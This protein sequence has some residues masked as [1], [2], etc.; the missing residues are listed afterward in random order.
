MAGGKVSARQKMINMMYLV[1]LA[2]L[3]MNVSKE[4]LDSF[5]ILKLKLYN[6][7]A[8]AEENAG[9]LI[10]AMKAEIDE[11]VDNQGK[12][13]NVGLKDSLDLVRGRT[14]A[15]INELN[16]HVVEMETIA[17]KDET[18]GEIEKKD[19]LEKNYQYWMGD[20]DV[21]NGGRG[22]GKAFELRNNMDQ[23]N[24]FLR[25]VYNDNVKDKERQLPE[26]KLED[27]VGKEGKTKSWEQYTFDGPVVANMAML[28][29]LKVDV[30]EKQKE[31]LT[32]LNERLGVA[33][34]KADKVIALVAPEA[35]IVPAGL[36]YRAKLFAVLSSDNIKPTFSS[37][38]GAVKPDSSGSF[39]NL[40]IPASGG[41]IPKGKAEG[42]Q[43]WTATVKVPKATGGTEDLQVSGK[44]TV[45]R[46]EIV[47][48]S[49]SIQILY[50]NCGNDVNIDVP[51]LGDLYNPQVTA[52]GGSVTQSPQN[53]KLFRVVP[54]A[55]KCR[56]HVASNT[57][58]RKIDIGDVD[59]TV[60]RPPKPAI[61][62]LMANGQPYN[63]STFIPKRSGIFIQIEPDGDFRSALPRD[64]RYGITGATV[65]A[66]LSLGPPQTVNQVGG[67]SDAVGT[68]VKVAL[69]RQV[70]SANDGTTVFVRVEGVYR[71]NFAGK[72]ITENFSELERT[73]K[74]N[75]K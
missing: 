38:M 66:Q 17:G 11:E 57:N 12:R 22:N 69:G 48:T 49:A 23:Y 54:T 27:Q 10:K 61:R 58:G 4:I 35:N 64:A 68:R 3:A 32:L 14:T 19:E 28:E 52:Q 73:I 42:V 7:A 72:Q 6:S 59:Y 8:T 74:F 5:E 62:A 18:T 25:K 2:M 47:V 29:A 43:A 15:L 44:F 41:V 31:L 37:S 56:V 51:A 65:L 36:E 39:G 50:R 34:F 63:G 26:R 53:K 46:P 45:R 1:L 9:D 24:A 21:A 55:G 13:D 30:L 20:N 67:A 33:V 60:I 40:V 16:A 71:I 75:V 70:A